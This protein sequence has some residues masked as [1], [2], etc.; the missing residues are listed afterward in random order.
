MTSFDLSNLQGQIGN[1]NCFI[2]VNINEEK[3]EHFGLPW[4]LN[5]EFWLSEALGCL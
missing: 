2:N 1:L 4:K 3:R 5:Y